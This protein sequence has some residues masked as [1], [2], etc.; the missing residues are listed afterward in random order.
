M[1]KYLAETTSTITRRFIID[2]DETKLDEQIPA[3]GAAQGAAVW[4]ITAELG[5]AVTL[6]KYHEEEADPAQITSLTD[7]PDNLTFTPR[8]ASFG[9]KAY[10]RVITPDGQYVKNT[11]APVT[12]ADLAAAPVGACYRVEEKCRSTKDAHGR[13][14]F[15]GLLGL[16]Y[17]EDPQGLLE[18]YPD[19]RII[20]DCND[21]K[22]VMTSPFTGS[23]AAPRGEYTKPGPEE[24]YRPTSD[25]VAE[26]S[27]LACMILS[28][29]GRKAASGLTA[30]DFTQSSHRFIFQAIR[31]LDDTNQPVDV[32]TITEKLHKESKLSLVGGPET[33]HQLAGAIPGSDNADFYVRLVREA[34]ENRRAGGEDEH[35]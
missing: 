10:H 4:G 13:W 8:E 2:V 24:P 18:K 31:E 26:D 22:W 21:S 28:K 30:S 17:W 3:H 11:D 27:A 6:H 25:T 32:V 35:A 9:T 33:I 7:L 23:T 34:A 12:P 14:A 29:H 16:D 20:T 15:H 19:G 5:D 1:P